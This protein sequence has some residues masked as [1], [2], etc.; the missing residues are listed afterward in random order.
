MEEVTP[1]IVVLKTGEQIICDLKEIFDGEGEDRKG[2]CLLMI[3]PHVLSLVEDNK[4]TNSDLQVK[5]TKWCPYSTDTQFKVPYDTIMAIGA[6]DTRLSEAYVNK[7]SELEQFN[8]AQQQ[9]ITPEVM[10]NE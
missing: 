8:N 6:S 3:H 9:V 10:S 4:K 2:V 5:F 1:S 7:V